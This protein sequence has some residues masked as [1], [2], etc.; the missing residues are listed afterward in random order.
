MEREDR[1]AE[2]HP[3]ASPGQGSR[4]ATRD[5]CLRVSVPVYYPRVGS[6][7]SCAAGGIKSAGVLCDDDIVIVSAEPSGR[8]G[9]A[10][11]MEVHDRANGRAQRLVFTD[12]LLCV[13]SRG[14]NVSEGLDW[15]SFVVSNINNIYLIFYCFF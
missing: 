4:R 3:R 8:M 7:S 6:R 15:W 9:S 14:P 12:E 2:P 1:Q 13:K 5:W 11:Q 10:S